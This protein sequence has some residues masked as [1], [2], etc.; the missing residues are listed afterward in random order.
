MD[1][2]VKPLVPEI[3]KAKVSGLVRNVSGTTAGQTRGSPVSAAHRR[4]LTEY[5]IFLL[6]PE[7]NVVTWNPGAE[8]IR[9]SIEPMKSL[10]STF[11]GSIRR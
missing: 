7:G 11:L 2:L 10:V 3:L 4:H 8:R 9:S 5:A 6:D 1:F